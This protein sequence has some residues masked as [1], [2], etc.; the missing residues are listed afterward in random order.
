MESG[1][2]TMFD[3]LVAGIHILGVVVGVVFTSYMVFGFV[4]SSLYTTEEADDPAENVRFVI[5][6]VAGEQVRNA[7]KETILHTARRFTTYDIYCVIDEGANLEDELVQMD[8]IQTVIVPESYDCAAK[9][10]GRAIQYFTETVVE[11]EQDYWYAFI[12]DDNKI[13]DD[14][15]LYEIPYYE[16]RGYRATNPV[17]KP[18]AGNSLIT[19]MADHIRFVDDLAIYRFFTGVLGTPYLGF[20][21]ELLCVRGDVLTSIGFDRPTIV[22]DFAFALEV[23]RDEVP[24]WQSQT[25]VSILSPHDIPSFLKQ[26]ARWYWGI[27]NYLSEAPLLSRIIV[28][29]RIFIWSIAV[30]SSWLFIPIWMFGYGIALPAWI[31]GVLALGTLVYIGTILIGVVRLGLFPG[32]L[33]LLFIPL[34]A[35]LEQLAPLYALWNRQTDFVVIDK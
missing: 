35:T 17:I 1:V 18:R 9:A 10:K 28:G 24:V 8:E 34:Y 13:L 7:L 6:T 23:V 32:V 2:V 29:S 31:T 16:S 22:E 4:L 26:R 3:A 14:R 30:T 25:R 12:D 33:L 21:G 19:F 15:F 20:H 5:V 27:A 11:A